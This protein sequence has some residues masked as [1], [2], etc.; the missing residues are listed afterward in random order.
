MRAAPGGCAAEQEDRRAPPPVLYATCNFSY[1]F[2]QS[3][4]RGRHMGQG[5]HTGNSL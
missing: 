2:T 5:S 1:L 4:S 3:V